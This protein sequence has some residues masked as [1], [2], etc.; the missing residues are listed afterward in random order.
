MLKSDPDEASLEK[1]S[2]LLVAMSNAK[3]IEILVLITQQEV[4]VGA[5][6]KAVGIR[7]SALS[8]HLAKLR[9]E[10]LV[11][12]RRDAQTIYY[13][14]QSEEVMGLLK[15]LEEIFALPQTLRSF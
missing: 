7:Q 3:R 2:A 6:A 10:G 12:T 15:V 11:T 13:S 1:A 4:V 14:S 8:Q 9:S 5:L